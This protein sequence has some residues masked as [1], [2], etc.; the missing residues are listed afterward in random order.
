MIIFSTDE[1]C[2]W[3][4]QI[5]SL[6]SRRSVCVCSEMDL[7]L[8]FFFCLLKLASVQ[9]SKSQISVKAGKLHCEHGQFESGA[10]ERP[11][12]T[13][14]YTCKSADCEEK[15]CSE[16]ITVRIRT[17]EDLLELDVPALISVLIG[18]LMATAL[19]GWAVYS[20][21]SQPTNRRSYIGNKASDKVN[22]IN[23]SGGDTYQRLN[24]RSDEYSTLHGPRKQKN[25]RNHAMSP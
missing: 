18:D 15:K 11:L 24:M 20:I 14:E 3:K 13:G 7:R 2:V 22:L 25:A 9:A 19:I 17:S 16:Q 23:N 10:T 4:Q 1:Q 6:R 5:F 21:C 12:E 8:L